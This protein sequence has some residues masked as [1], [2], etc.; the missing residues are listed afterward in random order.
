M[1]MEGGFHFLS[2]TS[3]A[4]RG[5]TARMYIHCYPRLP[6]KRVIHHYL[7]YSGTSDSAILGEGEVITRSSLESAA[8]LIGNVSISKNLLNSTR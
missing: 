2:R 3:S 1:K 6:E 7:D 8:C 4:S 5:V